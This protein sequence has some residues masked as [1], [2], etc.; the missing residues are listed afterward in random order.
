MVSGVGKKKKKKKEKRNR[1]SLFV[2][3]LKMKFSELWMMVRWYIFLDCEKV[4]VER[5]ERFGFS[6]I[7]RLDVKNLRMSLES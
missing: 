6:N 1:G 2:I 3:A 5:I 7:V 4:F